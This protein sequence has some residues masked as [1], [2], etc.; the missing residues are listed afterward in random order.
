[1]YSRYLFWLGTDTSIKVTQQWTI[2]R[3]WQDRVRMTQKK[4][5]KKK[6]KKKTQH[7]MLWTP[8]C[9]NKRK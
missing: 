7:N 2:Q 3:N 1:M 6:N 9:A 8:L 5:T 4:K